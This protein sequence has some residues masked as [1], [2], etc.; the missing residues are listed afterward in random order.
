[1]EYKKLGKTEL[2]VSAISLGTEYLLD[3]PR[4]A[5]VGVIHMAIER[6]I[7]YFDLF[8]AQPDFRDTM[9]AAFKGYRDKVILAAHL[10]A[11]ETDGQYEKTR[12]PKIC[13]HFF[14]D[15]LK[16][17]DT[18]HVDILLLHNIDTQEDYNDLM[19]PGSLLGMASRFQRE[20][21]A[22][23]IGFSGHNTVTSRHAVES[24]NIDVLLFPINLANHALPGRK[25][26]LDACITHQIGLVIMKP[27]A[28]GNL[29]S[30]ER[31]IKVADMQMGRR[32]LPGARMR[33]TKS[34]TITPVQC[35]SY[36][37]AQDGVSTVVPGCASVEQL[38]ASLA[39][40]D[41]TEEEKNYTLLLPGFEVFETGQCVYCNHCLPCPSEIDVGLTTRLMKK[42]E[43]ELTP[44]LQNQYDEMPA[45]ASD[46]IQCGDCM[47][48][49]PF[50][51]DVISNMEQA[52]AVFE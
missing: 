36:V 27:F 13:E 33:F 17:Y 42:A 25:E 50:A 19:K 45:K 6:G 39:C 43:Q 30:E 29:L 34:R 26:L 28:G 15:F 9:G 14:H 32:E 46:C 37:L 21:K 18:G 12:D 52:V 22:R 35:L 8:Y 24:G 51:V 49:C 48:R 16:R 10:G 47:D 2:D 41:A 3:L 5:A 20:G 31:L 11:A 40:L 4:E 23:F 38:E 44:E 7:N 1:M